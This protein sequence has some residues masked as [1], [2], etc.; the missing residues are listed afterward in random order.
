MYMYVYVCICMYMYV[1][2]CI[3]MYMYVYVCICMSLY[4]YSFIDLSTQVVLCP[5]DFTNQKKGLCIFEATCKLFILLGLSGLFWVISV[6]PQFPQFH[7]GKSIFPF[8]LGR[9][10]HLNGEDWWYMMILSFRTVVPRRRRPGKTW[11]TRGLSN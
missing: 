5:Q 1:Y 9:C 8:Q 10:P 2:V 6:Y 3:C 11:S 4:I 7:G